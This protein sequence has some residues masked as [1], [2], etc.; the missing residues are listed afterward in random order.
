MEVI[1]KQDVEN[2]GFKDD[3]VSVKNGYGRN[4]LI[5]QGKAILA[6]SSAKKMLA[7]TMRQRAKKNEKLV[8]DAQGV[9]KLLEDVTIK[10]IAKSADGVK[11]FGS[12]NNV[13]VSEELKKQGHDIESHFISID[14]RNVKRVGEYIAQLRLHR[15]VIFNLPFSIE[16]DPN[17]IVKKKKV[18][19]ETFIKQE[20]D[21]MFGKKESIDDVVGQITKKETDDFEEAPKVEETTEVVAD[22][23][24][25]E[26]T[27]TTE[28]T[29]E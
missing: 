10:I 13:N 16:A 22:T 28:N 14:G 4:F 18:K 9:A 1:L 12:V 23:K 8:S 15:E 27:E 24:E 21:S 6:T 3:V 7:E 26:T 5:P 19:E 11:L 20:D 2:L 17:S 29:E 25:V